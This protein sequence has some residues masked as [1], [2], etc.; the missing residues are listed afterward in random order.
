MEDMPEPWRTAQLY[1]DECGDEAENEMR[2]LAR[3][4][5]NEGNA[6]DAAKLFEAFQ[7]LKML[8]ENTY[9]SPSRLN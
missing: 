9:P 3:D 2:R 8:R 1:L 4:L 7:A 5:M 6:E